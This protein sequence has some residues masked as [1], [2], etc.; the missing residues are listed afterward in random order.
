MEDTVTAG[1]AD[2]ARAAP[3]D[4]TDEMLNL[5]V[6]ALRDG[7]LRMRRRWRPEMTGVSGKHDHAFRQLAYALISRKIDPYSYMKFACEFF[8]RFASDVYVDMICAPKILINY[9]EHRPN[10]ERDLTVLVELQ[11]GKVQARLRMGDTLDEILTDA[12]ESL[13]AI[14]RFAVAHKMSRKDLSDRFKEQAVEM[15]L[16]EPLYAKLLGD[17]LPKGFV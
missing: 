17:L 4:V 6:T 10:R 13:S 14:F 1:P 16:F 3:V 8:S 2:G 7:Y 12:H 5:Y 15:L 11:M 9:E